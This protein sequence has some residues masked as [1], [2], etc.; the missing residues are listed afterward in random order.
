MDPAIVACIKLLQS[1]NCERYYDH[2]FCRPFMRYVMQWPY[3]LPIKTI[4]IG[5]NPYPGDI[6]PEIGSALAYDESKVKTIPASVR[7]LAED[8]FNYDETPR[9]QTIECFK[10]SWRLL[11]H[12]VLMI[13]ESV[14]HRITKDLDRPNTG[15]LREMEAQVIAIQ[16]LL[17]IGLEMGQASITMIGMGMGASMMTSILRP[18]CP[19]D[20]ISARVM[21]CANPAA[22]SSLL[23][24]SS[25]QLI[26]LGK[27]HISKVLSGIVKSH[28]EMG[29]KVSN[30]E[31]RRQQGADTL[32]NALKEVKESALV[33][34]NERRSF[35]DRLQRLDVSSMPKGDKEELM[36]SIDAH[37]KAT[38]RSTNAISVHSTAMLSLMDMLT[39]DFGKNASQQS[40]TTPQ[41]SA[42]QSQQ[43]NV[44]AT[45]PSG[46]RRRVVRRSTSTPQVPSIPEDTVDNSVNESIAESVTEA[47]SDVVSTQSLAKPVSRSRRRVVR[48]PSV[49]GSDYTVVSQ[50][51]DNDAPIRYD[52]DQGQ[53]TQVR[54]FS[55]WFKD[56]YKDDPSYQVILSSAADSRTTDN[57]LSRDILQYIKDRKSDDS[58]YDAYD[59]LSDPDSKSSIWITDYMKSQ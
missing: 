47:A 25:S 44:P 30:A 49:A 21:T 41:Q 4:I 48:T 19:S 45:P 27:S 31:K 33:E 40:N 23:S 58:S 9:E 11:E 53:A 42:H 1:V 16:T 7:V 35:K 15:I 46:S 3:S 24:D 10:D 37:I 51:P 34:N 18:W 20:L 13:N 36:L 5:Q 55:T 52:M 14:F 39:K 28:S 54:S 2:P 38:D 43:L 32:K 57:P 26:T 56:N 12:G 29:P 22:Y 8:L 50:T 17:S 59:E 6:F